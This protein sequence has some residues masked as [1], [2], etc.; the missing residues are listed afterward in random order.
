VKISE[1]LKGALSDFAEAKPRLAASA[2]TLKHAVR[3]YDFEIQRLM[4]E[5]DQTL[6]EMHDHFRGIVDGA[7]LPIGAAQRQAKQGMNTLNLLAVS[8]E[9]CVG[10]AEQ[11]MQDKKSDA[12]APRLTSIIHEIDRLNEQICA[13]S[14]DAQTIPRLP[15]GLNPPM[16]FF[17]FEMP[18]FAE[19][20][21]RHTHV[22]IEETRFVY[23]KTVRM[24]SAKWRLK[25]FPAG[26]RQGLNSHLS[27]FL[28][29][30]GGVNEPIS[31]CY[32]VEF[33]QCTDQ[34]RFKKVYKSIFEVMDSWG[35]GRM[36]PLSEVPKYLDEDGG[37]FVK[38]GLRPETYHEAVK[39]A[40][41]QN[42]AISSRLLK[43][44][45]DAGRTS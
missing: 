5:R 45:K 38:L 44:E 23:S 12:L 2:A 42:Q 27:V 6:L 25:V 7:S 35:W 16:E 10:H 39:I 14:T 28:E 24:H 4:Q 29:L 9:T 26:N 13:F 15:D 41:Y 11:A 36:M 1:V 3:S 19:L 33:R 18:H 34:T 21:E 22:S 43:M 8:I 30:L 37:L 40:R 20:M 31:M 32:E 17:D